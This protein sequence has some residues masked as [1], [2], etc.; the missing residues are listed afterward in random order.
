LS[1]PLVNWARVLPQK[2]LDTVTRPVTAFEEKFPGLADMLGMHSA[3]PQPTNQAD[4]G[5]VR[6]ANQ[7]FVDAM[8]KKP[9]PLRGGK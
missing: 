5:M 1:S 8:N 4:P 2:A 3:P 6:A 7:S 9:A